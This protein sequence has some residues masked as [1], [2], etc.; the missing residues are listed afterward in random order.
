VVTLHFLAPFTPA[1]DRKVIAAA[2]RAR[3]EAAR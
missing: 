2:A 3:I 1:G